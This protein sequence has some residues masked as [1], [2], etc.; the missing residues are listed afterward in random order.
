VTDTDLEA[1]SS[2]TSAEERRRVRARTVGLVLLGLLAALVLAAAAMVAVRHGEALPGTTVAG[3]DVGGLGQT[4]IRSRLQGVVAERTTGV[5]ELVHEEQRF[6]VDRAELAVSV[7]LDETAERAVQAGRERGLDRVVGPLL[8][9][10]EPVDLTSSVAAGPVQQRVD[11]VAAELD[12]EPFPGA[13]EVDGVVVS[14]LPPAEGRTLRRE[15]AVQQVTEAVLAGETEIALPVDTVDPGTTQ[16][17]V[18]AVAQ[19][20]GALLAEPLRLA[21]P[22]ATLE[23]SPP[24]LGPLLASAPAEGGGLELVVDR[25]GLVALVERGAG[26]IDR[27]PVEAGFDAPQPATVDSQGDLTWSPQPAQVSARPGQTGLS[28]QVEEAVSTLEQ[29]IRDGSR[30][31]PLPIEQTPPKFTAADAQGGGVT[32]LLGTFTT[33]FAP[34]QNRAQNIR[35]IASVVDGTYVPPG[36]RFSLNGVAGQRTRAKGYLEDGAIID[37]E[38]VPQV[39]GGVSQFATTLFNAAFFAG[40]PIDEHKPHSF[41]ISRYPAGRESTV[42]FGSIDVKFTNDTGNGMV[43]KTWSTPR[44]VT[45]A[46]YGDN[47]GRTVTSTSGPRQ[48]RSGGGFTIS[49][50]RT[51]AGGDGRGGTRVFR[52]SYNPPPD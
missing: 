44:S 6:P 36:Q 14:A 16:A 31:A 7:D 50:T 21:S 5:V 48:P 27:R 33:Y 9:R 4:D 51:I 32:S 34:G 18:D 46:I 52:T 12:R 39:G 45:V 37:G 24:E 28:V 26:R 43:V 10:G 8:G 25:E 13:V 23:V 38:L 47:G 2:A 41:Y 40:L 3:V 30:E 19:Q 1:Q 42:S 11:E 15:E 20:A 49:V 29:L 22:E 35:L 17:D